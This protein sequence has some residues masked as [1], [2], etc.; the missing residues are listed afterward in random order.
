MALYCRHR[1]IQNIRDL[2]RLQPFLVAHDHHHPGRFGQLPEQLLYEAFQ[3]RIGA[4]IQ[5]N[6]SGASSRLTWLRNFRRRA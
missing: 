5:V 4:G 2:G 6:G 1:H 3:H